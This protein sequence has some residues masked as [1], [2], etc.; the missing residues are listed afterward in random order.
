[1]EQSRAASRTGG[2]R[3]ATR[4]ER[5]AGAAVPAPGRSAVRGEHTHSEPAAPAVVPQRHSVRDQILDALRAA[6]LNGRLGAGQV[7]SAPAIAAHFGVSPTPVREAMQVLVSEGAVET[8]P[9]RGFRV[10]EHDP[11][12]LAELA[13]VRN[14]LEVPP[15]LALARSVP[16]DR[17]EG[18]R[19]LAE[20]TVQAAARGDRGAYAEADRAFHRALLELTGN[21]QLVAAADDVRRRAHLSS[22]RTA[23]APRTT[24]L[25][26]EAADHL[27][28]LDALAD[29]D[30]TAVEHLLRGHQ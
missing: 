17:W 4:P 23:P 6:L 14:L 5:P 19:P 3:T 27:A 30:L 20:D 9:N 26:A 29:Q 16:A 21:R 13:E 1:M 22:L 11:H 28:L 24:D 12:D 2:P 18:L 7:Y 8:V 15:L 10:A 25:L